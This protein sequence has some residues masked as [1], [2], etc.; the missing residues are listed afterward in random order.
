MK[1]IVCLLLFA[2][3]TL[4]AEDKIQRFALPC[5]LSRAEL[6]TR[7]ADVF[8]RM[9]CRV[10]SAESALGFITAEFVG[11][12]RDFVSSTV[13]HLAFARDSVYITVWR[14]ASI[15]GGQLMYRDV[16]AAVAN[17]ILA[18]LRAVLATPLKN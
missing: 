9:H 18:E 1:A 11:D 5:P 17:P 14:T 13:F 6:V 16:E 15:S 4:H 8:A 2:T 12:E 3:V 10:T 7:A